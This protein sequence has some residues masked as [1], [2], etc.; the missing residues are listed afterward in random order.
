MICSK[1][2]KFFFPL[3]WLH[4]RHPKWQQ[5]VLDQKQQLKAHEDDKTGLYVLDWK[6]SPSDVVVD[7]LVHVK[8]YVLLKKKSSVI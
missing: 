4:I 2:K 8:T 3:K 7:S 1:K 5:K 6:F